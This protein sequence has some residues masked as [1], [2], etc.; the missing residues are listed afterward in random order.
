MALFTTDAA[1]AGFAEHHLGTLAPGYA[2]D[3]ILV[4]DDFFS[5]DASDIWRNEVIATVVSGRVVFARPE[6]PLAQ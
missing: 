6:S 3:F 4:R 1:Y 5:V 2:A